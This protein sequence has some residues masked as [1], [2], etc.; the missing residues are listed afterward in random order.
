[1]RE[2]EQRRSRAF[3]AQ[4]ASSRLDQRFLGPPAPMRAWPRHDL[5]SAIPFEP[6]GHADRGTFFLALGETFGL[7]RAQALCCVED[8]LAA[9][10]AYAERVMA[11]VRVPMKQRV[12]LRDIALHERAL[13]VEC[14]G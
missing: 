7:S 12:R 10:D 11:L 5:V 14:C 4:Y 3:Q 6:S 9:T 8:A 2:V 1:M 13:L